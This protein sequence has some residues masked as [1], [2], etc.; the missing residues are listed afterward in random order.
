MSEIKIDR[1]KLEHVM[2]EMCGHYCIF[3][4]TSIDEDVLKKHCDEC[5]LNLLPCED[6]FGYCP[7]QE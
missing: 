1:G 2:E 7:H 5:P 4:I 6:E 3:A